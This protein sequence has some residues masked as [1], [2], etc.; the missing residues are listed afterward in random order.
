MTG[1]LA[2]LLLHHKNRANEHKDRRTRLGAIDSY[3]SLATAAAASDLTAI[4][5]TAYTNRGGHRGGQAANPSLTK[6]ATAHQALVRRG[7]R[8]QTL[9][10][11]SCSPQRETMPQGVSNA[12][13]ESCEQR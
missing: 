2:A 1:F 7:H 10:S 11:S 6:I 13:H 4:E 8:V 5:L 3:I 9:G 12:S